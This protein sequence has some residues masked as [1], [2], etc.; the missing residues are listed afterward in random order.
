MSNFLPVVRQKEYL[1]ISCFT[2]FTTMPLPQRKIISIFSDVIRDF[3]ACILKEMVC[4]NSLLWVDFSVLYDT[5]KHFVLSE[6][7]AYVNQ[8]SSKNRFIVLS[9]EGIYKKY[10]LLLS[11]RLVYYRL[12]FSLGMYERNYFCLVFYLIKCAIYFKSRMQFC[13]VILLRMDMSYW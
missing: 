10:I 13:T 5:R 11:F 3:T 6:T 4:N 12:A 7:I 8:Q 9:F 2:N 1:L